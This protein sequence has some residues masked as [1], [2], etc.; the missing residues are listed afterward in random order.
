MTIGNQRL[1]SVKIRSLPKSPYFCGSSETSIRHLKRNRMCL[2]ISTALIPSPALN[3]FGQPPKPANITYPAQ[4]WMQL[5]LME[6][7]RQIAS[8]ENHPSSFTSSITT[9]DLL[10]YMRGPTKWW[11]CCAMTSSP[12]NDICMLIQFIESYKQRNNQKARVIATNMNA[13]VPDEIHSHH[14]HFDMATDW[15]AR[16]VD[17]QQNRPRIFCEHLS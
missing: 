6:D 12:S 1:V 4:N 11:H 9:N 3:K 5:L 10:A 8:N 15:M 17:G 7:N 13:S 2:K 14:H 16:N